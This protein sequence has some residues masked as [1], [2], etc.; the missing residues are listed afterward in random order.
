[1]CSA[2]TLNFS[3]CSSFVKK[4]ISATVFLADNE[5]CMIC[6][7]VTVSVGCCEMVSVS[8]VLIVEGMFVLKIL[9]FWNRNHFWES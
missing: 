3:L 9:H 7:S 8:D 4:T 2:T 5:T 6:R 1:M